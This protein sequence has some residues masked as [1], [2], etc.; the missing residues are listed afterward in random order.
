MNSFS[1]L[2]TK[3]YTINLAFL[4]LYSL[5]SVFPISSADFWF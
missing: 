5:N 3:F 2:I 4:C 1:Y